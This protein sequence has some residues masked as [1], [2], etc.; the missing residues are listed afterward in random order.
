M[1]S[2]YLTVASYTVAL[3]MLPCL[4][5]WNW[6]GYS[7]LFD[8]FGGAAPYSV[9]VADIF[10][11]VMA[12]YNYRKE[13]SKRAAGTR[14]WLETLIVCTLLQFGGTTCTGLL[15]GQPPSWL[16]S[17]T[18]LPAFCIAWYVTFFSPG[19]VWH[20]AMGTKV[21]RGAVLLGVWAS[22]AHAVT[23]WGLDKVRDLSLYLSF[24]AAQTFAQL[25]RAV[26]AHTRLPFSHHGRCGRLSWLTTSALTRQC[27]RQSQLGPFRRAGVE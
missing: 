17:H 2:S 11:S 20:Q 3:A 5:S 16:S 1:A 12:C 6:K 23:S 4:A 24:N 14:Y 27:S 13:V 9:S 19:D 25:T 26:M 18:A 15:L 8:W 21:F 7:D 22:T 10:G